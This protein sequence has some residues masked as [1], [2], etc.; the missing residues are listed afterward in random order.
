[1]TLLLR[2]TVTSWAMPRYDPLAQDWDHRHDLPSRI[3]GSAC[4][5][6]LHGR[7][8]VECRGESVQTRPQR[9]CVAC[10]EHRRHA[11]LGPR[12]FYVAIN[13]VPLKLKEDEAST[14]SAWA[15]S[16]P[17]CVPLGGR[18]QGSPFTSA[19]NSPWRYRQG[20]TPVTS[21][22]TTRIGHGTPDSDG[23]RT[24]LPPWTS[25]NFCVLASRPICRA[26]R[27]PMPTAGR[28]GPCL[29][30]NLSSKP[31]RGGQPGEQTLNR[32]PLSNGSGSFS[33][34]S[35]FRLSRGELELHR[36]GTSLPRRPKSPHFPTSPWDALHQSRCVVA[37]S[38]RAMT[39]K[40][41]AYDFEQV[42]SRK[43]TI[44]E[45]YKFLATTTGWLTWG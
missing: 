31:P 37:L 43:S 41:S 38:R 42:I 6:C 7:G 5:A 44:L 40:R 45:A 3:G 10:G 28:G 12:H 23:P 8:A 35:I 2:W 34:R 13:T 9:V 27:M 16:R 4:T 25:A 20:D 24:T 11:F 32:E 36:G 1:M 17:P 18:R 29:W 22:K 19:I 30:V 14:T 15:R 21:Y 39:Q 26:P 33:P